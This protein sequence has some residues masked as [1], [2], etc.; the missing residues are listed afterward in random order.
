MDMSVPPQMSAWMLQLP[1]KYVGVLY[2]KIKPPFS[3]IGFWY[4]VPVWGQVA[5]GQPHTSAVENY[6]YNDFP[7]H[8]RGWTYI[9]WK[10]EPSNPE[11]N[12]AARTGVIENPTPYWPRS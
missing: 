3:P 1:D 12:D 7:L 6:L 9:E 4:K 8:G 11:A 5:D 10:N 2:A